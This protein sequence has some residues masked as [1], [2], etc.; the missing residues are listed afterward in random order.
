MKTETPEMPRTLERPPWW[1]VVGGA[2]LVIVLFLVIKA[3]L[4]DDDAPGDTDREPAAATATLDPEP[5][6]GGPAQ[7]LEAGPG[8]QA[9]A[10]QANA[11]DP[12]PV[13]QPA[14]PQS[15]ELERR[16]DRLAQSLQA[17]ESRLATLESAGFDSRLTTLETDRQQLEVRLQD[18]ETGL[19]ETKKALASRKTRRIARRR[20][21][22]PRLKLVSV[23]NWGGRWQAVV[24]DRGLHILRTGS[25]FGGW[26]V[27][28]IDQSGLTLARGKDKV[29]IA[30]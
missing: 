27:A 18:L 11:V 13:G 24:E 2:A 15:V 5:A 9:P 28:S 3:I 29:T 30:P 19:N 16:L 1:I 26:T 22:P 8:G 12:G 20:H 23:D 14:P 6:P 10:P 17:L 4:S 21:P 7:A 25:S